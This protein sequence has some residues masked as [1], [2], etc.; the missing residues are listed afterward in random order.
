MLEI[1]QNEEI[2]S[3][4]FKVSSLNNRMDGW[5]VLWDKYGKGL[6]SSGLDI[7]Q[8]E[9]PMGQCEN[10]EKALT[11]ISKS[12][13]RSGLKESIFDSNQHIG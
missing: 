8:F 10:N 12:R 1:G 4:V 6:I 2:I 3:N 7:I 5:A 11:M 13:M 9:I